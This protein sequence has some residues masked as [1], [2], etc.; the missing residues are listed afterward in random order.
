MKYLQH[1]SQYTWLKAWA[2]LVSYLSFWQSMPRPNNICSDFPP[3][4]TCN[5][6]NHVGH[7]VLCL[8]WS[9]RENSLQLSSIRV[10]SEMPHESIHIRRFE[11]IRSS[12]SKG[13]YRILSV[14]TRT[15]LVGHD[16]IWLPRELI[17]LDALRSHRPVP[18]I[19][20]PLPDRFCSSIY[21]HTANQ[22]K[23]VSR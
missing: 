19:K 6:Q 5:I 14:R 1:H 21:L 10:W 2:M 11:S 7:L 3:D 22:L 15:A 12:T 18:A 20:P 8:T 9:S 16:P 23:V 17:Y 13:D 4:F